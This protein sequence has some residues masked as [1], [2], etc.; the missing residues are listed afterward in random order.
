MLVEDLG[1]LVDLHRELARRRDDERADGGGAAGGRRG[2]R[3]QVLE[4]RDQEGCG[5]A[6]AGLRLACD[7]AAGEGVGQGL[8]LDG[9]ATH[10]TGVLDALHQ[11]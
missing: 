11:G 10:K 8:R 1:V 7:I 6:G 2:V 9:C 3:E 5:L 4:E